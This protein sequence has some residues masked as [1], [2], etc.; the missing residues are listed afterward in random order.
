MGNI[1]SL[2]QLTEVQEKQVR[3]AAPGYKLIIDK[4]RQLLPS[5]SHR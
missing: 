4:A 3:A 2:H 1:L 5:R